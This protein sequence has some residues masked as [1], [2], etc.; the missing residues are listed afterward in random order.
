M[1]N[2]IIYIYTAL[3]LS[4]ELII[5]AFISSTTKNIL[6]MIFVLFVYTLIAVV[7]SPFVFNILGG[8]V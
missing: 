7:S 5:A 4:I 8:L 2:T 6:Y 3:I 1:E